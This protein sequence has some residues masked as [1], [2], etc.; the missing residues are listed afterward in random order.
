MGDLR[1]WG[2]QCISSWVKWL[3]FDGGQVSISHEQPTL[4]AQGGDTLAGKGDLVGASTVSTT[5]NT[6]DDVY[7]M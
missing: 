3:P 1:K 5:R 6:Y 7:G 2:E 4:T